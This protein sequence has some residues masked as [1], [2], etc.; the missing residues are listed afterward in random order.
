MELAPASDQVLSPIHTA[1]ECLPTA[2]MLCYGTPCDTTSCPVAT[3]LAVFSGACHVVMLEEV[4]I[5]SLFGYA[6]ATKT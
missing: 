6:R 4:S 1:A 3:H 2:L 5:H